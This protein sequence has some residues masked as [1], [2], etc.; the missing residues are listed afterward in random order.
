MKPDYA[1]KAIFLIGTNTTDLGRALVGEKKLGLPPVGCD[2]VSS[3][4]G[5]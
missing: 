3:L 4:V 2:D 5:K 1:G